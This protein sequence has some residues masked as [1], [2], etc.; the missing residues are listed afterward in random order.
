MKADAASG[1]IRGKS[2][3]LVEDHADS[4]YTTARMLQLA[5]HNVT[6][7]TNCAEAL[8]TVV[9]TTFDLYIV[10]V[11]LPDGDGCE[12]VQR[13]IKVRRAPAIALTGFGMPDEMARGI[14]AGFAAYLVK[15]IALPKLEAAVALA[16]A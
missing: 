9:D 2:I 7:A 10:D 1:V 3:L 6:I 13:L 4:A 14:Q 11:G 8:R 16:F 5:S 15:P 12:L